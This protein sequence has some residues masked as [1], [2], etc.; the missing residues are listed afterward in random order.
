MSV[1]SCILWHLQVNYYIVLSENHCEY[2]RIN[3]LKLGF[4]SNTG[5]QSRIIAARYVLEVHD[6]HNWDALI[7]GVTKCILEISWYRVLEGFRHLDSRYVW[8]S[9]HFL[10]RKS[11]Y[12]LLLSIIPLRTNI[13]KPNCWLVKSMRGPVEALSWKSSDIELS[14]NQLVN[15]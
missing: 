1:K 2:N 9:N 3:R 12:P 10:G 14:S 7:F 8:V 11:T 13:A 4:S 5:F 6:W 15:I